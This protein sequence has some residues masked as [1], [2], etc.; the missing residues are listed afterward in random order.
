MKSITEHAQELPSNLR[1]YEKFN[2]GL[3]KY[4]REFISDLHHKYKFKKVA[5]KYLCPELDKYFHKKEQNNINKVI[6]EYAGKF[7]VCR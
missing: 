7:I 5:Y 3:K 1:Y 2:K 4:A 6:K